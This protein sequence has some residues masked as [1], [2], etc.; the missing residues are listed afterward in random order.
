MSPS[1][2]NNLG[3]AHAVEILGLA[4]ILADGNGTGVDI[5]AY[6]GVGLFIL[7]GVNVAGTNPTLA[8]KLQHSDDDSDYADVT[9]GGFTGL[10]GAAHTAQA[11]A[12]NIGSLKKYVRV[13]KD[14]GGTDTP[15]YYAGVLMIAMKKYE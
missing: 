3:N 15:E 13:V 12:L 4:Q 7:D 8:M 1:M 14:I 2:L 10:T 5:S 9:G 6:D 11:L